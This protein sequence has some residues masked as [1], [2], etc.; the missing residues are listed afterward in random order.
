[1]VEETTKLKE[2]ILYLATRM[3]DDHHVGRGRI[4]LAKLLWRSDFAAFW[5]LGA[6]ITESRYHA[7]EHGTAPTGELLALRDLQAAGDLELRNEWDRQEI[8]IAKRTPRLDLFTREQLAIIDGQLDQYRYVTGSTMRDEAHDFPGWK[9]AWR[10]GEGDGDP[11]PFEAVFWDDRSTL[12]DWEE[13]HALA[14]AKEIGLEPS[15]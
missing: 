4:K 5:K 13:K 15:T 9:H 1:M 7:D 3:E 2:L 14:L 10:D 6:P 12:H 11:V 8:P